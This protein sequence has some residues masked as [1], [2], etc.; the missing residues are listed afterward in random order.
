MLGTVKA[1]V[2]IKWAEHEL[3]AVATTPYDAD[4]LSRVLAV[5]RRPSPSRRFGTS[6]RAI[7]AHALL[8]RYERTGASADLD[9]AV[10]LSRS[11]ADEEEGIVRVR[12]SLTVLVLSLLIRFERDNR[13]VDVS[14]AI[15][16]GRRLVGMGVKGSEG[17][18]FLCNLAA[19]LGLRFAY[20]GVLDD[21]NEAI[22][23]ARAAYGSIGRDRR[24]WRV[25]INLGVRLRQ[26]HCVTGEEA[27][28]VEAIRL[29]RE[30]L[31]A[32]AATEPARLGILTH[33][34]LW[35]VIRSLTS[36]DPADAA[37]AV[38]YGREA[39]TGVP[40]HDAYRTGFLSNLCRALLRHHDLVGDAAS[41]DEAIDVG[42]EAARAPADA[43]FRGEALYWLGTALRTRLRAE[44]RAEAIRFL[45]EVSESAAA[46]C[47]P[48]SVPAPRTERVEV[49]P[50]GPDAYTRPIRLR[51][52]GV[53]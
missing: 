27:D 44:D 5:L 41:L 50:V 28:I 35:Y 37:V 10:K 21:L 24:G 18:V 32:I 14:E 36:G 9:E 38:R 45:R 22:D 47:E 25:K 7:L 19:G 31:A 42:R 30:C 16:A 46:P 20:V 6:L 49:L 39:V 15:T 4:R 3:H 29:G 33:L 17:A 34:S 48:C 11:A 2:R 51:P 53:A 26:R 23:L 52:G 43:A 8:I 1:I 13:M 12:L 40:A